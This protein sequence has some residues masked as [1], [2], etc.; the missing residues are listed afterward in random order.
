MERANQARLAAQPSSSRRFCV[1]RKPPRAPQPQSTAL[2]SPPPQRALS[3][4][5]SEKDAH[6]RLR[7]GVEPRDS[8]QGGTSGMNTPM[9]SRNFEVRD[10]RYPDTPDRIGAPMYMG[11]TDFQRPPTSSNSSLMR[12]TFAQESRNGTPGAEGRPARR[13]SIAVVIPPTL[14]GHHAS[15]PP[16]A[17]HLEVPLESSIFEGAF[18]DPR[19]KSLREKDS[20]NMPDSTFSLV[21]FSSSTTSRPRVTPPPLALPGRGVPLG[22]SPNTNH[23]KSTLQ[24]PPRLEKTLLYPSSFLNDVCTLCCVEF[25]FR[26]RL[27]RLWLQLMNKYCVLKHF[28]YEMQQLESIGTSESYAGALLLRLRHYWDVLARDTMEMQLMWVVGVYRKA[29]RPPYAAA[30]RRGSGSQLSAA[31]RRNEDLGVCCRAIQLNIIQFTAIIGRLEAESCVMKGLLP[32]PAAISPLFEEPQGCLPGKMTEGASS[33]CKRPSVDEGQVSMVLQRLLYE[34]D[35]IDDC[36]IPYH[37]FLPSPDPTWSH[38]LCFSRHCSAYVSCISHVRF[39][40]GTLSVPLLVALEEKARHALAQTMLE[41]MSV[42]VSM[43]INYLRAD[44]EFRFSSITMNLMPPFAPGM[45]ISSNSDATTMQA[46]PLPVVSQSLENSLMLLQLGN[47]SFSSLRQPLTSVTAV[48]PRLP[49]N[50]SINYLSPCGDPPGTNTRKEYIYGVNSSVRRSLDTSGFVSITGLDSARESIMNASL[51]ASLRYSSVTTTSSVAQNPSSAMS[52]NRDKPQPP[53]SVWM[54]DRPGVGVGMNSYAAESSNA[55]PDDRNLNWV[56]L[57]LSLSAVDRTASGGGMWQSKTGGLSTQFFHSSTSMSAHTRGRP[58]PTGSPVPYHLVGA[59]PR[60][61]SLQLFYR[62]ERLARDDEERR[63]AFHRYVIKKTSRFIRIA[64]ETRDAL[65]RAMEYSR[66]VSHVRAPPAVRR[67]WMQMEEEKRLMVHQMILQMESALMQFKAAVCLQK[68]VHLHSLFLVDLSREFDQMMNL[69]RSVDRGGQRCSFSSLRGSF[70]SPT[71]RHIPNQSSDDAHLFPPGSRRGNHFARADD[72]YSVCNTQSSLPTPYSPVTPLTAPVLPKKSEA[73]SSRWGASTNLIL[74]DLNLSSTG[75][76]PAFSTA[77]SQGHGSAQEPMWLMEAHSAAPACFPGL[78]SRV[79][80]CFEGEENLK[81]RFWG[82][83][84]FVPVGQVGRE[85]CRTA[86]V[87]LHYISKEIKSYVQEHDRKDIMPESM[88]AGVHPAV[89]RVD[90]SNNDAY[91]GGWKGSERHGLGV[92]SFGQVGF[93][94]T[95]GWKRDLPHGDGILLRVSLEN[96]PEEMDAERARQKPLSEDFA[97][98]SFESLRVLFEQLQQQQQDG[99]SRNTGSVAAPQRR[100]A[101]QVL[102][103]H[104]SSGN[105]IHVMAVF[106]SIYGS[107][108]Q[109]EGD[110]VGHLLIRYPIPPLAY[111]TLHIHSSNG[112]HSVLHPFE[113]SIACIHAD[114]R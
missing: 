47:E 9:T 103:G 46:S 98:S 61:R 86:L 1:I 89:R 40:E 24:S 66:G 30:Q 79:K 75:P 105:L 14:H 57:A 95:G 65:S 84:D 107:T 27:Y 25:E 44:A 71:N 56:N 106:C 48:P 21:D 72:S 112:I 77:T 32:A 37:L 28:F 35:T 13:P 91:A 20:K 16:A 55:A 8:S 114:T 12:S 33:P 97:Q 100:Q 81:G 73:A 67:L 26:L 50:A 23:R 54:E 78:K 102:F 62:F 104:W 10:C 80:A 63:E 38:L 6:H 42:I 41:S 29:Y 52:R 39:I 49:F 109:P 99:P 15:I 59:T 88:G 82:Y 68:E 19:V 53:K 31:L 96:V 36:P 94:F 85:A 17:I 7:A 5:R 64:R 113:M 92:Y 34:K 18:Q 58:V 74:E 43:P 90:Y 110:S 11:F 3:T 76:D 93:S 69:T 111:Y 83:R 101:I 22:A 87:V 4:S 60:E 108:P 51:D 70:M 45:G 2:A